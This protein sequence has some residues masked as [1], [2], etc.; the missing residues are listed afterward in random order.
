MKQT[1]VT[2]ITAGR[3]NHKNTCLRYY[4]YVYTVN[5]KI[6]NNYISINILFNQSL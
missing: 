5:W 6:K 4:K 1:Q 2:E 3:L